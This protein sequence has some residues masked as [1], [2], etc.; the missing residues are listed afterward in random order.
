MSRTAP[1]LVASLSFLFAGGL[2]VPS[3][4]VLDRFGTTT[5]LLVALSGLG[6]GRVAAL[7]APLPFLLGLSWLAVGLSTFPRVE[8]GL[9]DGTSH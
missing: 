7:L 2:L 5:L 1:R 3:G 9:P 4:T 8:R 6:A